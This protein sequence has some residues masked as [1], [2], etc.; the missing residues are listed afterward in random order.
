MLEEHYVAGRLSFSRWLRPD[1]SVVAETLWRD[2]DG[3]GYYLRQDGT[4]RTKM[5]YRHGLADGQSV[6]YKED[7]VTVDHVAEF[8]EGHKVETSE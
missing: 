2:G 1:G 8:R 4:I 6:Y 7:G 5:E 3:N